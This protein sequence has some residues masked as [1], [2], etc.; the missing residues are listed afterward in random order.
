MRQIQSVIFACVLL[1]LP[2]ASVQAAE[3]NAQELVAKNL[4]ARGGA[5]A[6]KAL[7]AIQFKGTI[8]FPGVPTWFSKT[9]GKIAGPTAR[10]GQ[11]TDE[12]LRE[13]GLGR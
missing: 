2:I 1:S 10:L 11:D 6:L 12:V 3:P 9:P 5:E 8:R 4:E 7:R 13:L